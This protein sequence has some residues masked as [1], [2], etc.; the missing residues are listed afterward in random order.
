MKAKSLG[1]GAGYLEIDHR[2][3]PGLTPA[4]VAHVPGALAVGKGEHFETDVYQCSHC[5]RNVILR[6]PK[7]RMPARG[8]CP[9]CD[10]YICNSCER[11]RIASGGQCVPFKA[12]LDRAQEMA[13]KWVGQPDHPVAAQDPIAAA[14][15]DAEK[16][17]IVL[18]DVV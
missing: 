17:R 8:Y 15:A 4:D 18:T 11:T 1:H 3:S 5:Q 10:A 6:A 16:P 12:V 14:A 13:A 9:K 2:D 7:E